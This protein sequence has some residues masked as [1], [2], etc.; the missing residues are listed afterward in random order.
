[1]KFLPK[2]IIVGTC[3]LSITVVM[4]SLV[5]C[6]QFSASPGANQGATSGA[7]DSIPGLISSE[8]LEQGT[9]VITRDSIHFN[10]PSYVLSLEL[11]SIYQ[12]YIKELKW[13]VEITVDKLSEDSSLYAGVRLNGFELT[14]ALQQKGAYQIDSTG[15]HTIFGSILAKQGVFKQ[16]DQNSYEIILYTSSEGAAAVVSSIKVYHAWNQKVPVT[17]SFSNHQTA[18]S[19][20]ALEFVN[21]DITISSKPSEAQFSVLTSSCESLFP[22][23]IEPKRYAAGFD[24]DILGFSSGATK[25]NYELRYNDKRIVSGYFAD[26]GWHRNANDFPVTANNHK[27]NDPP[28]N[29]MKLYL[30]A[31]KGTVTIDCIRFYSGVGN[32]RLAS[33]GFDTDASLVYE[34]SNVDRFRNLKIDVTRWGIYQT[35]M[36]ADQINGTEEKQIQDQL[37]QQTYGTSSI[38]VSQ[39]S[40]NSPTLLLRLATESA[41]A[42]E[43]EVNCIERIT[44]IVEIEY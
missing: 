37:T 26:T 27:W 6:V 25:L 39:I 41:N 15:T 12:N 30:W 19:L 3:L 23:F 24:V 1:M 2:F 28:R 17:V 44:G 5:G 11:P 34:L 31:D 38:D 35:R 42:S 20:V 40:S 21:K 32:A 36:I 10:S 22:Y 8:D 9:H 7:G 29:T 13:F 33:E 18:K 16:G 43:R 14:S 4:T